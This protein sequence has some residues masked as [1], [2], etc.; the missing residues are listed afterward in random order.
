ML[1][2]GMGVL[3]RQKFF[4]RFRGQ[5]LNLRPL[6]QVDQRK[7]VLRGL[8]HTRGEPSWYFPMRIIIS[9]V[10]PVLIGLVLGRQRQTVEVAQ[11][12]YVVVVVFI[13]GIAQVKVHQPVSLDTADFSVPDFALPRQRVT[14]VFHPTDNLPPV[15]S[16]IRMDIHLVPTAILQHE[17]VLPL[18]PAGNM[19]IPQAAE[20]AKQARKVLLIDRDIQVGVAAGLPAKVCVHRPPAINHNRD[21]SDFRQVNHAQSFFLVHLRVLAGTLA[22][23][24]VFQNLLERVRLIYV[25]FWACRHGSPSIFEVSRQA[26][27][28]W[29]ISSSHPANRNLPGDRL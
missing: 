20:D 28:G 5:R 23:R 8:R 2:A 19:S 1:L 26:A 22:D 7:V 4:I 6:Q 15:V 17:I 3:H 10:Q 29:I 25:L 24:D 16:T 11:I 9:C 14:R 13:K 18:V 27:S 21:A 12:F